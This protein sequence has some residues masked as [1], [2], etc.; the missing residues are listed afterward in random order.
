MISVKILRNANDD[1][2]GF[3][4]KNHGSSIVCSAVS[5]L[6]LNTINSIEYLTGEKFECDTEPDGGFINFSLVEKENINK[7]AL[8]LLNSFILGIKGIKLDYKKQI[9]VSDLGGARNVKN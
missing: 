6:T 9:L 3:I 8:L 7:D 5:I 2:Y 4:V 1:P